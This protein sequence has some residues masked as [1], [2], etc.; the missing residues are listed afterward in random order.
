MFPV[1][2][3]AVPDYLTLIKRP[4]DFTTIKNQLTAGVYSTAE[5]F[6]A[7]VRQVFTN[8]WTYNIPGSWL[9]NSATN[10]ST[11]F[12]YLLRDVYGQEQKALEDAEISEMQNVIDQLRAEHTKL[13]SE[14]NKL[15]KSS[16]GPNSTSSSNLT[17]RTIT[18]KQPKKQKQPKKEKKEKSPKQR[19]PT[20]TTPKINTLPIVYK[21]EYADKERLSKKIN[22]L[23][24]DNLQ[25]MVDVLSGDIAE[26]QKKTGELEI[27][28]E[29]LSDASLSRLEQFVDD[30]LKRQEREANK[31]TES[32]KESKSPPLTDS[33][34]AEIHHSD[35]SDSSS[36]S[37]SEDEDEDDEEET[38]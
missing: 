29:Q 12:E 26:F 35:E 30:C 13:L 20:S 19:A 3:L 23:T 9:Y 7:D 18:P 38:K 33:I 14:L 1:D 31:S 8:C 10:L 17:K 5:D 32:G 15:V 34:K 6:A 11:L 28:L 16:R 36:G 21:Y 25:R 24:L 37:E 2:I 22:T 4:M 27:D